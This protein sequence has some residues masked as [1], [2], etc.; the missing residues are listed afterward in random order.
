VNGALA[1][2]L[3][4]ARRDLDKLAGSVSA[5][6]DSPYNQR[7]LEEKG[8]RVLGIVPPILS[9]SHLDRGL[10]HDN[11]Q[12]G[13]RP[14]SQDTI[15]WLHV[16]RLAPNKCIQDIIKA[17][18]YYHKWITP[19]SRL[20]L[21]GSGH[22][23][24]P[25]VDDL[26]RLVARLGLV[27]AVIFTGLVEQVAKFYHMAHVYISMSEHEGFCIPLVEAMYCGLPVI[28]YASTG[29][30]FTMGDAGAL[31]RR[32]EYPLVAEVV[33]EIVTNALL[34]SR[35]VEGQRARLAVFAPDAT[36]VKLRACL[37]SI[38]R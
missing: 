26:Q 9:F 34:R 5:I 25:Y 30:P 11:V 6:C 31:I 15:N 4:E 21:V 32:K 3:K 12:V 8:I 37:D 16:G 28:A 2:E 27:E 38:A 33:H 18:Y 1:Q 29:I 14:E 19:E 35:L 13:I 23:A 20:F 22:G 36:Y 10:D 7:E 24:Q 17:F